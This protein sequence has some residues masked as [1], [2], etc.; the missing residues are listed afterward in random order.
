[1]PSLRK[2][3]TGLIE[4]G[5]IVTLFAEGSYM[6]RLDMVNEFPKG[7]VVWRFDK[8]DMAAA[9]KALGDN[10]CLTGN[11]PASLLSTGTPKAVKENCRKLIETCGKNGGYIL[12]TGCQVDMAPPENMR[13][14]MEAAKEYGVY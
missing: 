13:A 7:T 12:N 8:T 1:V 10:C 11:V 9:Y 4:E 14:M 3:I 5:L 6:D 2:V